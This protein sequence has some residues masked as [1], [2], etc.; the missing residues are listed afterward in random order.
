[1]NTSP[2]R[3]IIADDHP[4][5]HLGIEH[6]LFADR[7][8]AVVAT[9]T[10]FAALLE[11]LAREPAQ[12]VIL[13]L[14]QMGAGPLVMVRALCEQYPQVRLV[15]FSSS[16]AL[17]P[18]LLAAGARGY[19]V[20]EEVLTHLP[21]AIHAVAADLVYC[22][23]L[24][25]EYQARTDTVQRQVTLVQQEFRVLTFVAQGMKT[26]EI[27]ANLRIAVRTAQ[28]YITTLYEKTGCETRE[29]L[30]MWYHQRYRETEAEI[31]PQTM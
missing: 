27:A 13:D 23:P 21:A 17:A 11:Q 4:V 18:E 24:V 19:V 30:A 9:V 8:I 14:N 31:H 25:Q 20:K 16:V 6:S 1:M 22:S 26:K 5:I 2:I 29:E 28:N 10:S 12:V 3:V 15:I 7:R